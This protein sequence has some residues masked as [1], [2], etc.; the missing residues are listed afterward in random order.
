MVY[1]GTR[2][3]ASVRLEYSG[4]AWHNTDLEPLDTLGMAYGLHWNSLQRKRPFRVQWHCVAQHRIQRRARGFK[5]GTS[6]ALSISG[7]VMVS[8]LLQTIT[9]SVGPSIAKTS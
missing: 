4:T 8:R 6:M 3:S 2:F 9:V 7:C 5:S 1:T